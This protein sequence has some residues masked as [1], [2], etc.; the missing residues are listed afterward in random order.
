MLTCPCCGDVSVSLLHQFMNHIR[1]VH[2][3][4]PNFQIQCNLQGCKKTFKKFTVFRNHVYA[5]HDT[6]S[7]NEVPVSSTSLP[8][9]STLTDIEFDILGHESSGIVTYSICDTCTC[10]YII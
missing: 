10:V 2:A 7:F 8:A 5:F 4:E 1:L 6:A 9:T 3:D